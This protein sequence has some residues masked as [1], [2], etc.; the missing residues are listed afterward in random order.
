MSGAPKRPFG[1]LTEAFDL[2][3]P[4]GIYAATGAHN[5]ALRGELLTVTWT[6]FRSSHGTLRRK[7]SKRC[8]R[9]L[10]GE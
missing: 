5:R 4:D 6:A 7:S 3:R 10:P 8:W 1:C 9:K 2:L